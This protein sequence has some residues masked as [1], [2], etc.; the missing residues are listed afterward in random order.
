MRIQATVRGRVVAEPIFDFAEDDFVVRF[1]L[2]D[3]EES[4]RPACEV[5][6]RDSSVA[7]LILRRVRPGDLLLVL[8]VLHLR[9]VLGPAAD[10][11][12]AGVA[13]IEAESIA[14]ALDARS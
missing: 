2:G 11:L 5:V 12:C 9:P 6:S 8:G 10:D 14:H 7:N 4:G 3:E 1:L 13:S